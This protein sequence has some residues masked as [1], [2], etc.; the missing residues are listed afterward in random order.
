MSAK[1]ECIDDSGPGV[2]QKYNNVDTEWSCQGFCINNQDCNTFVHKKRSQICHLYKQPL[3]QMR[4]QCN[5]VLQP[6]NYNMTTC[7][8]PNYPCSVS[9]ILLIKRLL[10]VTKVWK[11][12]CNFSLLF[13]P[14]SLSINHLSLS[15]NFIFTSEL[16]WNGLS[17]SRDCNQKFKTS[18][19]GSF[20]QLACDMV[21]ECQYFTW[22]MKTEECH[23][24]DSQNKTC[25]TFFGP[26]SPNFNT[27]KNTLNLT[28]HGNSSVKDNPKSRH[29]NLIKKLYK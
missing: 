16:H 6:K 24:L 28:D 8:T 21:K 11:L 1:N 23:L 18:S 14:A 7:S 19:N 2:F 3:E 25:A 17:V 29:R 13:W 4:W 10:A 20:C 5:I 9:E 12:W 22:N 27:C 26:K 15:H